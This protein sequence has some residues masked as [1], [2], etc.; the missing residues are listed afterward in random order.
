MN[1]REFIVA[2]VA[3]AGL[4]GRT[5]AQTQSPR[6]EVY[7]SPTCGFCSAWV[8]H[9]ERAGFLVDARDIDQ[10]A[11]YALKARSGITPEL[12]SCHTAIV[13]GYV[14]EGHVPAA[15]VVRLL[16]ERPEAIGLSVPGMPIGS[17]GMEMG[18]QRDTFDTLL[19]RGDGSTEVFERH[20]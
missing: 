12:A 4:A 3:A 18:N 9:M 6:I 19:V 8:E 10:D 7:K 2:G 5:Q 15:D 13:D 16:A 14:V 1:R 20:A 11:L 17:P